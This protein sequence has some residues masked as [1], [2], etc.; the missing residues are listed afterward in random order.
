MTYSFKKMQYSGH[1]INLAKI[2]SRAGIKNNFKNKGKR[3]QAGG[4]EGLQGP[5]SQ[6]ARD[7]DAPSSPDRSLSPRQGFGWLHQQH[8]KNHLGTGGMNR[9]PSHPAAPPARFRDKRAPPRRAPQIWGETAGS[10]HPEGP[11][12]RHHRPPA[13]PGASGRGGATL[14]AEVP[15]GWPGLAPRA[16]PRSP[17]SRRHQRPKD[18]AN[19]D[20][21]RR[22]SR[23]VDPDPSPSR[24]PA[25]TGAA[26][27]TGTGGCGCLRDAPKRADEMLRRTQG[28]SYGPRVQAL[29]PPRSGA[30]T[31]S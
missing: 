1:S 18:G 19:R 7:E 12:H 30:L 23:G 20:S 15:E 27:G 26:P 17:A 16:P 31:R 13:Q 28:L 4:E 14:P 10:S 11:G 25:P 22:S 21:P 3:P 9:S 29:P 8:P 5:Q 6:P 24:P 2:L